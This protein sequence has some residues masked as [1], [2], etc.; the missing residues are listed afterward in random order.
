MHDLKGRHQSAVDRR[1]QLLADDGFEHLRKLHA[2]LLLLLRREHVD[3]AV[4][5]VHRADG[6]QRRDDKVPCLRRGHG[7]LDGVKIAH[8]A[9]QDHVRRL[10]Q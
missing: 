5:G 4:N 3:D 8:L 7:G 2:D 9:Q 10:P 1:Q 6:V